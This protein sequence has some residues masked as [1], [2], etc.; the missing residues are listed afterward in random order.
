MKLHYK[1][2]VNSFVGCVDLVSRGTH[3]SGLFPHFLL[4]CTLAL[5]KKTQSNLQF[6]CFLNSDEEPDA[7]K[8]AHEREDVESWQHGLCRERWRPGG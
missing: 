8:Q 5:D 7:Q 2:T 3:P 6:V 4:S 1:N